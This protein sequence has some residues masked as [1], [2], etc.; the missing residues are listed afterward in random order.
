[1]LLDHNN[2]LYLGRVFPFNVQACWVLTVIFAVCS[3]AVKVNGE[4]SSRTST[5]LWH[6]H[7][8]RAAGAK[9]KPQNT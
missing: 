4:F 6:I 9:H 1:M 2:G 3:S 8:I 7:L 5:L